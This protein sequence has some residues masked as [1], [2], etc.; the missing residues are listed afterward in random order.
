MHVCTMIKVIN[1]HTGECDN[2]ERAVKINLVFTH[3]L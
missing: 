1:E 3:T 2:L